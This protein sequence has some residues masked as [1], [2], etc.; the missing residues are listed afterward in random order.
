MTRGAG[1]AALALAF[2][3]G[4]VLAVAC[5]RPEDDVVT[6]RIT[7]SRT[8]E[9]DAIDA[10]SWREF[11]RRHP[12]VRVVN[13]PISNAAAYRERL[14]ADIGAGA[15]PDLLV[16]DGTDAQALIAEG[17]LLDLAPFVRR[18]GV[19]VDDFYPT[20]LAS[21]TRGDRLYALPKGYTPV[22][23]FYNRTLF[24]QAGL[25]HPTNGW[26]TDEFLR[27]ARALT[28]DTDGDGTTDQWGA[29]IDRPFPAWQAWVWSH[30]GDILS[31]DGKRASGYLDSPQTDS[32][33]RL[34]AAL[35]GELAV[36]PRP[37]TSRAA[38]SAAQRLFVSGRVGLLA[39]D[40]RLIPEVRKHLEQG[41]LSLGVVS[42][43]HAPG[44]APRTTILASGYAVPFNTPHRKLAVELAAWMS[45][46]EA[47]RRRLAAG[48]ELS[49]M[50]KVQLSAA[51]D[52]YGL[53]SSFVWQVTHGSPP[54]GARV[55][56]FREVESRLLDAL[57]RVIVG[58][59]DVHA[60]TSDAARRVD[61]VLAR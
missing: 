29:V 17:M 3:A 10:E 15:P 21:F 49:T 22:V 42:V 9:E 44:R 56:R 39:G 11:E 18:V 28:R 33:L 38:S 43:P 32:A 34:L 23:Y 61:A 19:D 16:L 53:E 51:G 1:L 24:D 14:I 36:A 37:D 55:A 47:Q 40:H 41:R 31:P 46:P 54:W 60:V 26:S 5:G 30:G 45:G 12:G 59:Q 35:P 6:L 58:R 25:P 57:D 20:V 48:L 13:E 27:A 52:P 7:S 4:S 50:P 2:G 8:P